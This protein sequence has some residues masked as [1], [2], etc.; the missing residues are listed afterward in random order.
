M[1]EDGDGPCATRCHAVSDVRVSYGGK[2]TMKRFM[3]S[4]S[5]VLLTC[6]PA[7][8]ADAEPGPSSQQLLAT[9]RAWAAAAAAGDVEHVITFWSEDA[10]N[11]FPG[12]PAAVGR[13]AI[14]AL[15]RRYRS[16]PR[17]SLHWQADTAEVAAS[18]EIGY[19]SGR[20]TATFG[21]EDG[22]TV[23]RTGHYVCIWRKL[24]NG[25]WKCVVET[26][27]FESNTA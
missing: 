10:V 13:D 18:G 27:V 12:E 24:D 16:D 17:Y 15:V 21:A 9:D 4:L 22:A 6:V 8:S 11:F 19:T 23:T 25:E 20:F 2:A 5:T 7:L 3:N 14:I 26:S 1:P